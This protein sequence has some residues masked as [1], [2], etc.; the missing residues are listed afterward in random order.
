LQFF[1]RTK[2]S[3]FQNWLVALVVGL[4][5]RLPVSL[6][7]KMGIATLFHPRTRGWGPARAAIGEYVAE[8]DAANRAALHL[9][10]QGTER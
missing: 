1:R 2:Q 6:L 5:S 8:C 4:V 7:I 9:D 3:L 10:A